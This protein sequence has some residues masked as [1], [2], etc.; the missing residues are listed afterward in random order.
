[1]RPPDFWSSTDAIAKVKAALL[2]PLSALYLAGARFQRAHANP[3]KAS[4]PVICVGNLTI[5]GTGKTPIAI[6]IARLL[7]ERGQSPVFLTRGYGGHV[8]GPVRVDA[9][10][11]S[12]VQVGDEALLLA[13]TG[14]TIVGRDR[15]KG[16]DLAERCGAN[17]II[18]DDGHQ[19]F[20][21]TK[22]LSFV[23]VDAET[24]FGN[25]Y[26]IPAGPLR[27]T[28]EEGLARAHA[29]VLVGNGHPRLPRHTIP[30]IRAHIIPSEP[31]VVRGKR[32][33]AF[34]GIGRPQKFFAT[35]ENIGTI[36][37]GTMEF[38][39]H[40]M[41]TSIELAN[42]RDAA[43]RADAI[44]VTTEKDWVRIAPGQRGDIEYVAVR[45][46][47]DRTEEIMKLVD[48]LGR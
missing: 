33:F 19:N 25:G 7:S 44:L 37:C 45:A 12:A 40:H 3:R 48:G 36:I 16:A 6:A 9:V 42:L 17:V 10:Q 22:D 15:A 26:V 43:Q 35:L 13:K 8:A 28:I 1:M 38:P 4:V 14:P 30:E 11:H 18:M 46:V 39:D 20:S 27:E 32:I 41:F 2:S 21:L 47:F 5:G 34:A 23:V 29:I 24:G 31:D